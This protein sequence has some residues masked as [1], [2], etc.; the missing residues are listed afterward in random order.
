M[1]SLV[2]AKCTSSATWGSTV[3]SPRV[4]GAAASRSLRKYS[5]ALTSCTV[6]R[7]ISASSATVRGV[8]RVHDAAQVVPLLAGQASVRPAPRGAT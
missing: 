2:Q 5:T 1:S 6:I 3:S 4:S 7:S 8:E